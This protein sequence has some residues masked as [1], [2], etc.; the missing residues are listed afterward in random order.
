M[1][2]PA[3]KLNIEDR[4]PARVC[5]T[6][7]SGRTCESDKYVSFLALKAVLPSEQ[8]S[9]QGA[10]AASRRLSVQSPAAVWTANMYKSARGASSSSAITSRP[11]LI[12]KTRF[13]Y[14]IKSGTAEQ[15]RRSSRA[16]RNRIVSC[17]HPSPCGSGALTIGPGGVVCCVLCAC[18][19]ML[20]HHTIWVKTGGRASITS[21]QT[22]RH[23]AN[24]VGPRRHCCR[25]EG[26]VSSQFQTNT[27]TF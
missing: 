7:V 24:I 17:M 16:L 26:R 13:L 25:L 23:N 15:R 3:N 21:P 8:R 11:G 19:S 20:W 9:R 1:R 5:A 4:A 10:Q 14:N 18:E 12:L 22:R 27:A 2:K 6:W